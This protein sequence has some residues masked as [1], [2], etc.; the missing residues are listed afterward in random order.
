MTTV[1]I[2]GF[3]R[4]GRAFFRASLD[5]GR[6]ECRSR[7]YKAQRGKI[8]GLVVARQDLVVPK[9]EGAVRIQCR[10]VRGKDPDSKV[11]LHSSLL[12]SDSEAGEPL[13]LLAAVVRCVLAS[14]GQNSGAR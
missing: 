8:P 12:R 1:G 7:W 11:S 5:I 9:A 6:A 14:S 2:N 10:R 3:G 13:Q 4:V